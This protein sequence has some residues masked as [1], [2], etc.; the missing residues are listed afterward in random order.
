MFRNP[1]NSNTQKISTIFQIWSRNHSNPEYS[2]ED[3]DPN[4]NIKIYSLSNGSTSSSKR[5]VKMIGKCDVYIPS[6][7]FG[8][9]KMKIYNTFEELPN[10]K[11]YGIVFTN[12]NNIEK[13][14]KIDW[15]SISFKSTNGAFN[16]RTSQIKQ[17]IINQ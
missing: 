3:I 9:E 13:C 14:K 1:D 10:M 16:L 7:C 17:S 8:I 12:K 5:N 11:G 4:N 2:I 6:T 15:K